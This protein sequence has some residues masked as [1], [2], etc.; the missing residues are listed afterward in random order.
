MDIDD[1][2][3]QDVGLGQMPAADKDD[4]V[5]DA[6]VEL[7]NRLGQR[8]STTLSLDELEEFEGIDDLGQAEQW[9]AQ[10]VP[11][12]EEVA[13]QVYDEFKDEIKTANQGYQPAVA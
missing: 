2:F 1:K 8:I 11:N 3:L 6:T 12:Y 7:E 4:F 10:R 5:R 13:G 9:L